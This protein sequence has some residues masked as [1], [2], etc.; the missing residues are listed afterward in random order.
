MCPL[1]S[2]LH[3]LA[4]PATFETP[5][6]GPGA[7]PQGRSRSKDRTA[8]QPSE[9]DSSENPPDTKK[10]KPEES[11]S[12]DRFLSEYQSEDD[13]SF[14]ELMEK[15][16]EEQK[17]RYAWLYEREQEAV[18][19]LAGPEERLA[20]AGGGGE[21]GDEVKAIEDRPSSVKTWRYTPKNSLMYF[22]E[23]ME[24]SVKEK[25]EGPLKSRE[26]MH[27]NTRLSR[28]FIKK[29]QAALQQ[30]AG[31]GAGQGGGGAAKDK[32]GI[33]GKILGPADSP[34]V[35]G[36]GFLATPQIHPGKCTNAVTQL[37]TATLINHYI[38]IHDITIT[39]PHYRCGCLSTDD[40]GQH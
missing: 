32:V 37:Y 1:A 4:T 21:R 9:E 34:Q 35:N 18:A 19:A 10:L 30:A 11:E 14:G 29:S 12:L 6:A 20:I 22:P 17:R 5:S 15:A 31:E 7:T 26:V 25:V 23:G 28:E 24:E 36:Y 13:A 2:Y 27:A 40:V 38:I 33:D 39:P 8:F 3:N 16:K